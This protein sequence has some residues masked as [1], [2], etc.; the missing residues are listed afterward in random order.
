MHV[1]LVYITLLIAM[2][3]VVNCE[4]SDAFDHETGTEEPQWWRSKL[5]LYDRLLQ[6]QPLYNTQEKVEPRMSYYRKK[7]FLPKRGGMLA[8][9]R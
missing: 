1:P 3:I 5:P 2:E 4:P 8:D 7:G 6:A 9:F